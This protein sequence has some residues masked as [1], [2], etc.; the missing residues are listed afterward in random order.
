MAPYLEGELVL[1]ETQVFRG[2]KPRQE[3]VDALS[4]NPQ[5]S[6]RGPRGQNKKKNTREDF[7]KNK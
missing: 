7:L 5:T 2:H 4:E 3:N 6:A 1:A